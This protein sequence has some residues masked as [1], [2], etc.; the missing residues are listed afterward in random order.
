MLSL[1]S[2]TPKELLPIAGVPILVRVLAE[3]SASG[4]ESVLV[5]TAPGKEAIE[6]TIAPLVGAEGMPGN[7]EFV[8]QHEP[9]GLA[10]AI[11]LGREFGGDEPLAVALPDNLFRDDEPALGQVIGMYEKSRTNVVAIVRITAS[12]AA[13]RGPTAV[14][15]G[16]LRGDEYRIESIPSKGAKSGTFDTLGADAAYTAV[17]RFVF[18]PS[19]FHTID[20]VE[21]TLR[22]GEEI[23]DVPVMQSLLRDNDITGRLVMGSFFDVGLIDGFREAEAAFSK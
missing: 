10:D 22:P 18:K 1:T 6:N 8:T 7:I 9:R 4:I 2:G 14:Y 19:V 3:C 20:L 21:K 13:R 12:E 17:G 16:E 5:V 11:R 15:G 23:D